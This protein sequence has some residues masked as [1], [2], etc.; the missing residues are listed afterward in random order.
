MN[1]P[2]ISEPPDASSLRMEMY[3]KQLEA[4]G[5]K[6]LDALCYELFH[7]NK[8]G[9]RLY[10][11]L[12]KKFILT[13]KFDPASPVASTQAIYW[14]GF[15]AAIRGLYENGLHHRARMNR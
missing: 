7:I 1:N 5:V 13:S 14:E 11:M 12:E 9:K 2:L 8:D 10:E 3:E 6:E 15:R 4:S